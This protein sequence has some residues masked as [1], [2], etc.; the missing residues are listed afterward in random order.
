MKH[1]EQLELLTSDWHGHFTAGAAKEVGIASYEIARWVK[2][3]RLE[4]EGHGVY[5]LTTYPPS[6]VEPY[7]VAVLSV[8][9]D[10][11]L[12]GESVLAM[13]KL[14]PTNPSCIY[15]ASPRRVRRNLGDGI[16]VVKVPET[17]VVAHYEGVP[18]QEVASAIRSTR[19]LVRKDRRI[20]A[21]E[22]AMR[23]GYL[24]PAMRDKLIKEVHDEASA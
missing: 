12:Y 7:V 18:S 13:L 6:G 23:L 2:S 5:R 15:V 3:G 20:G 21:I 24:T 17:M 9:K 22:E 10:A 11:Y 14:A 1:F 4:S 16:K 8:G 19:G